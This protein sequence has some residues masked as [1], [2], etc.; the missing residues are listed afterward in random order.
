MEHLL[1]FVFEECNSKLKS[2]L[3]LCQSSF[4]SFAFL[5]ELWECIV[6]CSLNY[7]LIPY[8][9]IYSLSFVLDESDL[10]THRM[11]WMNIIIIIASKKLEVWNIDQ[12]SSSSSNLKCRNEERATPTYVS[13]YL[14]M[15]LLN[16]VGSL[17]LRLALLFLNYILKCWEEIP[18]RLAMPG[19]LFVVDGLLYKGNGIEKR[20]IVTPN[21]VPSVVRRSCFK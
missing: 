18:G 9:E 2:P 15:R 3:H 11:K 16:D 12:S 4:L 10:E 21:F 5:N 7:S 6:P 20:D 1:K 14:M 8:I 19:L 13:C 17:V